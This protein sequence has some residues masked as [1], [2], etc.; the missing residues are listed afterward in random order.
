MRACERCGEELSY[1][2]R[3]CSRACFALARTEMPEAAQRYLSAFESALE[4]RGSP[5]LEEMLENLSLW[6]GTCS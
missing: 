4:R 6:L 3:F 1:Q 2:K 5:R